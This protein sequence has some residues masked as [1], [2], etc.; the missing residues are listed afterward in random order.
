[1]T[2][3]DNMTRGSSGGRLKKLLP[4]AILVAIL[5]TFFAVGGHEYL[6]FDT[7]Q[8]NYMDLQGFVESNFLVAMLL[9]I[10]AYTITTSASLPIASLL[11]VVGG[12]L[13][14]WF[15]GTI[16]T[17][18]GA[19]MGATILFTAARTSFGDAL[20]EKVNP[21]VGRMEEGFHKDAVSYLLFLRLMPVFPF[22]V[23]NLVPAF[24]G[25]KT[26][27]FVATTFIGIIPGTAVYNFIGSGLGDIFAS[28]QEFSLHNA[29]N[30]E[31]LIGLVGLAIVALAPIVWRKVKGRQDGAAAT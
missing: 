17:V 14:G 13:F 12:F 8:A 30:Q 15:S 1:M 2:D 16:F 26:R 4:L 6:T 10:V 21:Y 20:R 28:G 7:L 23:V 5:V 22:F 19:T 29:I 25:V 27:L 18:I 24:L 31:I 11:T 9:Y 3:Q